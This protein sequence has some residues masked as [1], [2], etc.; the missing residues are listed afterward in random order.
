MLKAGVQQAGTENLNRPEYLRFTATCVIAP[1]RPA[2][3]QPM[4][5]HGKTCLATPWKAQQS[6]ITSSPRLRC[7]L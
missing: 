1:T 6:T 5:F 3:S 7:I 4:L 2:L